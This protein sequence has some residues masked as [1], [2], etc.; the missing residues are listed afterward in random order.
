MVLSSILNGVNLNG[1]NLLYPTSLMP[2]LLTLC[3]YEK[4]SNSLSEIYSTVHIFNTTIDLS[5]NTT[6]QLHFIL[7]RSEWSFSFSERYLWWSLGHFIKAVN[8]T[9]ILYHVYG[10]RLFKIR[11]DLIGHYHNFLSCVLSISCG[12][13]SSDIFLNTIWQKYETW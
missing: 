4:N 3:N 1:G 10:G 2:I 8:I 9:V 5:K 13:E 7:S 12:R 6:V 11:T